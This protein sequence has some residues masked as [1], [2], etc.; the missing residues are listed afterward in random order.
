MNLLAL[1]IATTTGWAFGPISEGSCPSA[2]GHERL[3][4]AGASN[5]RCWRST[6]MWINA[7][8]REH[9][10]DM[11]VIEA[12]IK[13]PNMKGKSSPKVDERLGGMQSVI[14]A[15]VFMRQRVTAD[16][17][18]PATVRKQFLGLGNL[19]KDTAKKLVHSRCREL[20]WIDAGNLSL[21]ETDAMAL[22]ATYGCINS[23]EFRK[24]FEVRM[25]SNSAHIIDVAAKKEAEREA[26]RKAN[27]QPN[28]KAPAFFVGDTEDIPF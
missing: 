28:T 11:V 1:D 14:R 27:S 19:P 6:F 4:K 22:W 16:Q 20:G 9:D 24:G 21:D 5:E 18:P 12:K 8:L 7:M 25:P 3:A 10:P 23:I 2:S 26:R 17:I 13:T 15:V